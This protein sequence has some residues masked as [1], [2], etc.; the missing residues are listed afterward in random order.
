MLSKNKLTKN[1]TRDI[2]KKKKRF[3]THRCDVS[4]RVSIEDECSGAERH[5]S[6]VTY[7]KR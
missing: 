4:G 6:K 5:V 2:A 1:K 7:D 3:R